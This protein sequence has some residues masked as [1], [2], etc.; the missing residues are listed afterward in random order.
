MTEL[1]CL[2]RNDG[3]AGVFAFFPVFAHM[4]GQLLELAD[5]TVDAY[6]EVF[7]PFIMPPGDHD[8]PPTVD[9]DVL[10]AMLEPYPD[11]FSGYGEIGLYRH[12][13]QDRRRLPA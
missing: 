10:A 7:T 11:L 3:T 12:R 9:G 5:R 6:P 8:I 13:R 4:P 1:G 2:L